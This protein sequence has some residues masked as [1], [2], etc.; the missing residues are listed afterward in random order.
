MIKAEFVNGAEARESLRRLGLE[1]MPGSNND[2][3]EIWVSTSGHP[4]S[5]PYFKRGDKDRFLKI[6]FDAVIDEL[7]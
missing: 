7:T 5:I 4:H 6:A 1:P 2:A 3:V